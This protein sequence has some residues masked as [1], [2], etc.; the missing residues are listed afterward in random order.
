MSAHEPPATLAAFFTDGRLTSIPR[1]P[2]RRTALLE[3]LARTLFDPERSYTEQEVNEALLTVHPDTSMLRR[4]LVEA[5]LLTRTR[6]G[7]SYRPTGTAPAD[8]PAA[9]AGPDGAQPSA[10]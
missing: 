5:L 2:A 1:K 3:H 6:D 10:A 4:Y 7:S 9:P 8:A